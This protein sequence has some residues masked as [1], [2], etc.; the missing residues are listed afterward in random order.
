MNHKCFTF[1]SYLDQISR[2]IYIDLFNLNIMFRAT[3][4]WFPLYLLKSIFMAV[5]SPNSLP[6]SHDTSW[7][8]ISINKVNLISYNQIKTELLNSRYDTNCL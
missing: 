1:F 6:I 2:K 7:N 5:H 3:Y 4:N 8:S